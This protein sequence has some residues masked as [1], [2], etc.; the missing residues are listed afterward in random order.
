VLYSDP[1]T[2]AVLVATHLVAMR[3]YEGCKSI[4]TVS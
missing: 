1:Q 4:A 3:S 2:Q